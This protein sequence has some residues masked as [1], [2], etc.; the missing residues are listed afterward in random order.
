MSNKTSLFIA[1]VL[2][3]LC[4]GTGNVQAQRRRKKTIHKKTAV[5]KKVT[6]APAQATA[7]AAAQDTVPLDGGRNFT[8]TSDFTPSLKPAS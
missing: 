4:L 2:L 5:K 3:A 7:Q 6:K 8:V 1:V